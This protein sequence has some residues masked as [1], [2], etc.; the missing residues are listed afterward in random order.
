MVDIGV[1]FISCDILSDFAKKFEH[2][3]ISYLTL[4]QTYFKMDWSQLQ[5]L[6]STIAFII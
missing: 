2:D 6:E 5:A 3:F 1:V 4:G